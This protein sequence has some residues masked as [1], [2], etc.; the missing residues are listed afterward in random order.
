LAAVLFVEI[1]VLKGTA[2][3][4]SALRGGS[5]LLVALLLVQL[6]LGAGTWVVN[7]GFPQWVNALVTTPDFVVRAHSWPQLLITTA[8][9]AVGSLI[10]VTSLLLTLKSWPPA[11]IATAATSAFAGLTLREALR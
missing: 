3:R 8:H 7:Y 1:V 6:S 11:R 5:R 4:T 10:L 2:S 9:V